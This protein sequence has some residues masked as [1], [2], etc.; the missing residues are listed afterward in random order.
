MPVVSTDRRTD[1]RIVERKAHARN[2]RA[3]TAVI[4]L[5][6]KSLKKFVIALLCATTATAQQ[7]PPATELPKLV[8]NVVKSKTTLRDAERKLR[9]YLRKNEQSAI[10]KYNL[11]VLIDAQGRHDEALALYDEA[12]RIRT[13]DYYVEAR[14]GCARRA[15]APG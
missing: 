13:R 14:A 15:C 2:R 1:R 10:A 11:A 3:P 12:M 9:K 7:Q 8:E 5:R 4:I 6:R